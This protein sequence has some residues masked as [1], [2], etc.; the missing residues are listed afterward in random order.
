M[1]SAIPSHSRRDYPTKCSSRFALSAVPHIA[2]GGTFDLARAT[3]VLS[4]RAAPDH[5]CESA[6]NEKRLVLRVSLRKLNANADPLRGVRFARLN[7]LSQIASQQ[8]KLLRVR[9]LRYGPPGQERPGMLD[10]QGRL[11]E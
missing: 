8:R 5:V 4:M 7:A 10:N 11:R 6:T 1:K 3:R 9:L 2:W